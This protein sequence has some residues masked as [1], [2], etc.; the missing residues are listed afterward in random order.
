MDS[1]IFPDSHFNELK[2]E[3]TDFAQQAVECRLVRNR[4]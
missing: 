3:V 1:L 4:A 2:P